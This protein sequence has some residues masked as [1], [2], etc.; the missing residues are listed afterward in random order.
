MIDIVALIFPQMV[1]RLSVKQ[2]P[3]MSKFLLELDLSLKL[4]LV[5]SLFTLLMDFC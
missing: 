3:M 1:C 2:L 5:E 4:S